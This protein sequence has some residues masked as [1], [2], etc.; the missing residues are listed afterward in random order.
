MMSGI[1]HPYYAVVI[2][3]A[4][5]AL[6]GGGLVELWRIR[7]RFTWGGLVLGAVLVASAWW[8]W[9]VL[10]RTPA[11]FP[12]VGIGAVF[13]AI[14]AA[15]VLAV[16]PIA[17]DPRAAAITRCAAVLGLT[18][19]LVGPGLYTVDTM[20]KTLAGGDPSAG[21]ARGLGAG[22]GPGGFAGF[23]G[24]A[25]GTNQALVDYLLANR[26]GAT[27]LVA[28]SSAN[29]AGPLQ[30]TSGVPVMAMGGFMGSDP[31]PTLEQMQAY[32]RE[33]RLRFVMMGG[34]TGG[35]GG[36]FGGDGSGNV[37]GAR[38]A[39]V[40]RACAP[41]RVPGVSGSLYDCAGAAP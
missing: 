9:Q 39:W 40:A 17:D 32:V 22:F 37:A 26:G 25:G 24:D 19:V 1:A 20:G 13:I 2:A 35:P 31:A 16:P 29:Q 10:D 30:L 34:P 21:P 3:P 33:G 27:W 12:G 28:V 6:L 4:A 11:F 5:A 7:A 41:V 38:N 15:L 14:A 23:P 36:F 18:A 8:G